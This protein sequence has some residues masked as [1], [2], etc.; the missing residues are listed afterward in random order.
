MMTPA[1]FFKTMNKTFI[2]EFFLKLDGTSQWEVP[3]ASVVLL[4]C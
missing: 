2:E 4:F 3:V 1:Q